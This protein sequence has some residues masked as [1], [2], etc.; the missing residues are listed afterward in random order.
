MIQDKPILIT[1]AS[2]KTGR[3]VVA[4]LAGKDCLVRALVRRPEAG[5]EVHTLGAAEVVLGD[6]S[7]RQSLRRAMRGVGQVLHICP[8]MHPHEDDLARTMVELAGEEAVGRFI[9][10]SVLQPL[11]RDVPHHRRKLEAERCLVDS[12]LN[13]TILQPCR[14]MQ[15]LVPIWQTVLTTGLHCMP[16]RVSAPF[17]VVD[18][19]D[20]A[21]AAARIL[22]EAGHDLATYQLAGPE[23]LSQTDMA[24]ILTDLLGRPIQALAK[25]L[26]EFRREAAAA[27]LPA[28]RIET[29]T[30]MN[31]HYDRHGLT[32]NP[33]VLRW[34]IG[35]EPTRFREFVR[36]EL[37]APRAAFVEAAP[38]SPPREG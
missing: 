11:L 17:S 36:R 34:I 1:G 20:I 25:P 8:P 13:Y 21:E 3:R 18:L 28:E 16:F 12:G 26:D 19:A 10:Y 27:G 31:A 9:L 24:D 38:I 2:G 14:Y 37:M 23:A 30:L 15:H 22:T 35:R 32:G 29:M 4:A 6:F 33:N 7:D 5:D